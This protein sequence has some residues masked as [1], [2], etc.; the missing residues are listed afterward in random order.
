MVSKK[1]KTSYTSYNF[2][3]LLDSRAVEKTLFNLLKLCFQT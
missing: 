3:K 1:K 2:L